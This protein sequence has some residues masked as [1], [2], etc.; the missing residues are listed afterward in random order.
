VSGYVE[1]RWVRD[2]ARTPQYGKG[3]RY[4][5]RWTDASGAERCKS[6]PDRHKEDAL[7]HAQAAATDVLRGTWQ[8]PKSAR[9]TLR[10]YTAQT[11]LPAQGGDRSTRERVA[12]QLK[13]HI[14]PQLGDRRLGQL[15]DSPSTISAWLNKLELAK[16][17]KVVVFG[18]LSS[19][20]AAAVDDGKISRNPCRVKTVRVPYP[21]ARELVP[22]QP[23]VLRAIRGEL[24]ERYRAMIECGGDLGLRQ[25]ETLGLG[26]DAV[27]WLKNQV[28][29]I[30]QLRI[31]EGR[32]VV[33]LPKGRKTRT[34]PLPH[35]TSLAL[36]A[37][38]RACPPVALR[39]P[40]DEPGGEMT[41]ILLLFSTPS[42]TPVRANEFGKFHWKPA[43]IRAGLPGGREDGFHMLRHT[44][45]SELLAG[46][47]DIMTVA[48][49]LG[50]A[51][52][53]TT[54]LYYGHFIPGR[55]DRT[56]KIIDS[57]A[58]TDSDRTGHAEFGSGAGQA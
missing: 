31:V 20:L 36:A 48:R 57:R 39:L 23:A 33:K 14:L 49:Y 26:A 30:R 24:P 29:V 19:I 43:V 41:E 1:D 6:F 42:G 4:R 22:W 3:M 11:W 37:H 53:T 7:N 52:A 58:R 50:H 51:R 35:S 13:N 16:S 5:A 54:L 32:L 15:A 34:V 56:R 55:E 12:S 45:A 40:L 38:I 8:D 2:G 44:F 17:T 10:E 28:R 47:E 25:G 9:I 21:D 46:G 27:D 18:L